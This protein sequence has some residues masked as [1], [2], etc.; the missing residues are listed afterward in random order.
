MTLVEATDIL[1][2]NGYLVEVL[3]LKT[4]VP[5]ENV[6]VDYEIE[7]VLNQC[8]DFDEARSYGPDRAYNRALARAKELRPDFYFP[9]SKAEFEEIYGYDIDD[10]P[11]EVIEKFFND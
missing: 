1:S 5:M 9:S 7:K 8:Y 4:R 3:C 10:P 6:D 2:K 11:P